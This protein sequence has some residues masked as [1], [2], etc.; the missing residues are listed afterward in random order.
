VNGYNNNCYRWFEARGEAN[1]DYS[2]FVGQEMSSHGVGKDALV[3]TTSEKTF[4]TTVK[5]V[6]A[7]FFVLKN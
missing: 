2:K 3:S 1:E 5:Y 4:A 6:V 7:I